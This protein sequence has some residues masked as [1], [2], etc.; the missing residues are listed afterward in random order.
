MVHGLAAQ[1]GGAV[2]ISSRLGVGTNVE[3]WLP[4]TRESSFLAEAENADLPKPRSTGRIL[5]VDDEDIA[6]HTTA[7]MLN[8]L[9][10]DTVEAASGEDALAILRKGFVPDLLVSDH[11]CGYLSLG[12]G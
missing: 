3:L 9:G 5:L 6:R 10:F 11:G 8:D 4:L 7:V 2:R 12:C 1:L